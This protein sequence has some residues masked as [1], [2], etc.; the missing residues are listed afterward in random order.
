MY[1]LANLA[2][3]RGDNAG[4]AK[5]INLMD[6]RLQPTHVWAQDKTWLVRSEP[7]LSPPLNP[8]SV[9]SKGK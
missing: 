5:W 9:P 4:A 1:V 3:T 6:K 8:D 2:L 7:A